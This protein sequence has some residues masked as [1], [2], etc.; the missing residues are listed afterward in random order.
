MPS[1]WTVR[2]K[3]RL[4]A[5]SAVFLAVVI[6]A[7]SVAV[8]TTVGRAILSND[9]ALTTDIGGVVRACLTELMMTRDP[10]GIG[11]AVDELAARPET[12][13]R[14][15]VLDHAGTIRYSTIKADVGRTVDRKADPSCAVCHRL[16]A[17]PT[18]T[19]HLIVQD[20]RTFM[21]NVTVLP[22]EPAC[23]TCH[24]AE[25]RVNGKVV[26]DR[27]MVGTD[28][29]LATV[30]SIVIGAGLFSLLAIAVSFPAVGRSINRYVQEIGVQ[31]SEITVL[32][33][34]VE[35]LSKSIEP[36]AL[37]AIMLRTVLVTF[38]ADEVAIV[39]ADDA[40]DRRSYRLARGDHAESAASVDSDADIREAFERWQANDL[41]GPSSRASAG[42]VVAVPLSQDG[43]HLGLILIRRFG[44]PID[45]QTTRLLGALG[46]HAGVA[47]Q[48]ARLYAMA[49]TDELT[50]LYTSRHFRTC[51]DAAV[52]RHARQQEP[53]TLLFLDIDNF[54]S[55]NDT[56][57]HV[58]GDDVLRRVAGAMAGALREQDL[59]FR[60]GGEE[61]TAILAGADTRVGT[62]MA[63]AM[64]RA[65]E[66][67]RAPGWPDALYVTASIGVAEC[68]GDAVTARDLVVRA[69]AALYAAKR[70]GK[71]RVE[72]A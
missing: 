12:I 43:L 40:P 31:E 49:V 11:R 45:E 5:G 32:Y 55:I 71:N 20:G 29:L 2:L 35:H 41:P 70:A 4:M 25:Q 66:G 72:R 38:D 21:R 14:S 9:Q 1:N 57:G 50:R 7:T 48:N 62:E 42:G 61:L 47:L 6:A 65:I 34:M 3:W 13:A 18:T 10:A 59:A 17:A 22:N 51:L 69:D 54:K 39:L 16:A 52:D 23:Q 68:P 53:F 63:E 30:R 24:A 27:P 15:F 60:Y 44:R 67:L 33:S 8:S 58:T 64:R 56:F 37:R 26:I 28:R 46:R 36:R 19:T